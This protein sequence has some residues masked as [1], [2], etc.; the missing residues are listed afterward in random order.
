MKGT[1]TRDGTDGTYGRN[2]EN[3]LVGSADIMNSGYDHDIYN[4]LKESKNF[5]TLNP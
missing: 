4:A 5:N 1:V 2:P 3:P